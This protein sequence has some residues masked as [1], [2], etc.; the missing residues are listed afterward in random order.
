MSQSPLPWP[1][2]DEHLTPFLPLVYVAW[3]DG[4]L[5]RAEMDRIRNELTSADGM[6]A[7]ARAVLESWLHADSPPSPV[8]LA[9]LRT[10]VRSIAHRVEPDELRSL[11]ALGIALA[12][13]N[14]ADQG[15]WATDKGRRTLEAVE[16]LLGV[17]G[18]EAARHLVT[19]AAGLRSRLDSDAP[20]QVRPLS[21]PAGALARFLEADRPELRAKVLALLEDPEVRVPDGLPTAEARA[22]VFRALQRLAREKVGGLAFPVEHGGSGDVAASIIAFE[23]LALGNLS[24]TIKFGVQFGLFGGSVA[25]LGT[26]RHRWEYLPKVASLEIAGIYGMTERDHGSNVREIETVARYLP[27]SQE[28]EIH[29]PHRGARKDWLGN[30]AIDGHLATVFAQLEVAGEEH[31]VHA[32]LVPIRDQD[33]RVLPG[34]EVEDCG[35]KVGLNGI[36]NG[37]LS[38]DHVRIP[39]ENLLNRFADVTPAG[40][41]QSAISSPGRRFFTMIGTLVAGRISIAVGALS[42]V[43]TGLTIAVRYSERRRQ[44]GPSGGSEVP[45]LDYVMQQRAL[46]PAVAT[47]FGL[48][49][50]L[51]DLVRDYAVG[52]KDDRERARV[53]VTAAGLKAY[54]TRHALDA[55]QACREAMGGRGYLAENR[56]GTLRED[57]DVFATFE[58]ANVVLWQLVAKGLLS[59]FR[60]EVADLR[61]W[62]VLRLLADR[63][64]EEAERLNPLRSRRTSEDFLRSP[65]TQLG[66]FRFREER[67]LHTLARR[68]TH[69]VDEGMDSFHA[70]NECQDHAVHL[71]RAHVERL[72]L[73]AY[74]RASER[75]ET[76]EGPDVR[77]ALDSLS[78]LYA[79]SRLE[80]D[81]AWFLESGYMENAQSKAIRAAVNTLCGEIRPIATALVD[82]FGIP[83]SLL[84]APDGLSI[85][86][87]A[88]VIS[89]PGASRPQSL[90]ST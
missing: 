89:D 85:A 3:A 11:V 38:F 19:A 52:S 72:V 41:Y 59:E 5:S 24:L 39:R 30:A 58:G 90:R 67:L 73:E 53:E 62:G 29:T 70:M 13:S 74:R 27:G 57:V 44:F 60:T 14:A 34:I 37:R 18:A 82:G 40:V 45:I 12:R 76:S 10:A 61:L 66:A 8:A 81:R 15:G 63:A 4:S 86:S 20:P 1:A 75:A 65:D 43:K 77:N 47:T 2:Q 69:R 71:A 36:D 7:S 26:A 46:L 28:F 17:L 80:A 55:L 54:T 23:T 25:Q 83:D 88:A 31:G 84:A 56:I 9:E 42:A 32:F 68:I 6:P 78:D 16:E 48:H 87:R 50:A 35:E 49:F 33:G 21:F 79:L 22:R 51:R 64:G